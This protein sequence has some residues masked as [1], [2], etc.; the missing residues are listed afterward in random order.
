MHIAQKCN[1]T[2]RQCVPVESAVKI[3]SG[4]HW[5]MGRVTSLDGNCPLET[6]GQ[7]VLRHMLDG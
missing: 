5:G 2:P 7:C 4:L 3:L 6:M 1:V